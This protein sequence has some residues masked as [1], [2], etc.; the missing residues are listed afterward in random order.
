MPTLKYIR[1]ALYYFSSI[2]LLVFFYWFIAPN[3]QGYYKIRFQELEI[4]L[5]IFMVLLFI[6]LYAVVNHNKITN[7]SFYIILSIMIS[8]M[9]YFYNLSSPFLKKECCFY[10]GTHWEGSEPKSL[11]FYLISIISFV[12]IFLS[13]K[14]I[15][16]R[17]KKQR[18]IRK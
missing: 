9:I 5:Y 16:K 14:V 2:A 11:N 8:I 10:E 4:I 15:D 1:Y 12:I 7:L 17:R 13:K 3:R 18:E 6:I